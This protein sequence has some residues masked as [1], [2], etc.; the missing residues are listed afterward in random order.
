MRLPEDVLAAFVPDE[1]SWEESFGAFLSF[2]SERGSQS[3]PP[4]SRLILSQIFNQSPVGLVVVA[5]DDQVL[6]INR[7]AAQ[8]FE[9]D[10]DAQ[11]VVSWGELRTRKP[12]WN[13]AEVP[14]ENDMDPIYM[15]LREK[16]RTTSNVLFKDP[17]SD[18][19]EWTTVTAFPVFAPREKTRVVAAVASIIDITDYKGM[20][21]ILY[22]QATHDALT[23][24]CNKAMLSAGVAKA[25]S[26]AKRGYR[27]G[28]LLFLDVDYFKKVN[29]QLG[30]AAGDVLLTKVADRIRSELREADIVA[31][32]G[33]DEFVVLISDM[34]PGKERHAAEEVAERI[35]RS[36]ALPFGI[37][38]EEVSCSVSIGIA[39]YPG[40]GLDE[41][42][43]LGK[44]DAA[45]YRAKEAGRNGWQ[46]WEH[47]HFEKSV[48]D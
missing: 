35:C 5:P 26:R 43:L 48:G 28:A 4:P 7:L 36:I 39:L 34:E 24:L 37:V 47:A 16:R 1:R 2:G 17:E 31:R 14:L 23:G 40:H 33:G 27:G 41:E 18:F 38:G 12:L 46:V 30:H 9:F 19:E 15:A 32:V 45:M 10:R 3:E 21:D 44:A 29:D 20:Q 42:L 11:P 8:L 25:L 13:A 22:Y 6:L